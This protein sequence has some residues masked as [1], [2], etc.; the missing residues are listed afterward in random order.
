[1][2]IERFPEPIDA[3]LITNT[4]SDRERTN[5]FNEIKSFKKDDNGV[6]LS[7]VYKDLEMSSI[8]RNTLEVF[9][10]TEVFEPLVNMNS[11]YGIY[12]H[13]NNHSTVVR[14]YGDRQSSVIHYDAAA[15]TVK[16]F[17][18]D[19]PKGFTGGNVTLQVGGE[20]AYE[21][22]IQDNMSVIFPSSYYVSL[23]EVSLTDPS[24]EDSGLFVITSYLFVESN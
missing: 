13:V 3:L 17:L 9:F 8:N 18:F 16:T 22:D 4:F 20:I 19:E 2:N 23:S 5:V 7:D 15:F 12:G 11:L 1:M 6:W 14:Y 24:I 10:G 21:M